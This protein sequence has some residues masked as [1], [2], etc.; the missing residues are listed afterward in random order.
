MWKVHEINA[1]GGKLLKTE[2]SM[3]EGVKAAMRVGGTLEE[4]HCFKVGIKRRMYVISPWLFNIF[5]DE[6]LQEVKARSGR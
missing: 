2:Q 1:V 4:K 5:I 6:V 3:H